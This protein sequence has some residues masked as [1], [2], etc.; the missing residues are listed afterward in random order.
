MNEQMIYRFTNQVANMAKMGK[1]AP[2][3]PSPLKHVTNIHTFVDNLL[4]SKQ[5]AFSLGEP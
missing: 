1:K 4:G 5:N 2:T 3:F